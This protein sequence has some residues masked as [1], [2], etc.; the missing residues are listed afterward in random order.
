MTQE[1]LLKDLKN[2]AEFA[3]SIALQMLLNYTIEHITDLQDIIDN[4]TPH[5]KYYDF[6]NSNL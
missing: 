4:E 1:I 3:D 2:A 5:G 6:N